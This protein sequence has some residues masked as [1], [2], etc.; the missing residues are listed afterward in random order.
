MSGF[1]WGGRGQR[2]GDYVLDEGIAVGG[3]GEVWLATRVL[4]AGQGGGV[5]QEQVAVKLLVDDVLEE[6][7]KAH[8]VKHRNVVKIIDF[9]R[10]ADGVL[11]WVAMEYVDGWTLAQLQERVPPEA[12][13]P[14]SAVLDLAIDLCEGLRAVHEAS[15]SRDRSM[16]LVHRDIKPSNVMVTHDGQVKLLDFG[17]AKDLGSSDPTAPS[18]RCFTPRYAAPE[19]HVG[20]PVGPATDLYSAA[21]VVAELLLGQPV[22]PEDPESHGLTIERLK[23]EDAA[24]RR[25]DGARFSSGGLQDLL[26]ACLERDPRRRP[27]SAAD[28][29]TRLHQLREPLPDRP[30]ADALIHLLRERR[31]PPDLSTP[32]QDDWRA[33]VRRVQSAPVPRPV[34]DAWMCGGTLDLADVPQVPP[35]RRSPSGVVWPL[36]ANVAFVRPVSAPNQTVQQDPLPPRPSPEPAAA[37]TLPSWL[38]DLMRA[39]GWAAVI[40]VLIAAGGWLGVSVL[41]PK[42]QEML[43]SQPAPGPVVSPTVSEVKPEVPVVVAPGP[44]PVVPPPP[45]QPICVDA[46]RDGYQAC[47]P[48]SPGDDCDDTNGKVYP[49]AT[50]QCDGV[51]NDCNPATLGPNETLTA[52][53]KLICSPT[54]PKPPRTQ[55]PQ[56]T[57]YVDEDGDGYGGG[58]T[59]P[60]SKAD[61]SEAGLS[62]RSDDCN[63][64]PGVGAR[65]YPGAGEDCTDGIDGDCSG[66]QDTCKGYTETLTFGADRRDLGTAVTLFGSCDAVKLVMQ[67]PGMSAETLPLAS[68]GV[69]WHAKLDL[70]NKQRKADG[71]LRYYYVCTSGGQE[72]KLYYR[73]G[74]YMR[75]KA[76]P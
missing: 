32:L 58:S 18:R 40:G 44:T 21:L 2:F 7:A 15:D 38:P 76:L 41:W 43:A 14:L 20:E 4:G 34:P 3:F 9:G 55:T 66:T 42:V 1:R 17:I 25:I 35:E 65:I 36:G 61:C 37:L 71:S 27:S 39:F 48:S 69:T 5:L 53:G 64:T 45:P 19:Q 67:F 63:D 75:E 51:D 72:R 22:F 30:C 33:L 57:C 68:S 16:R 50:E 70:S 54:T 49:G 11:R 46:D 8:S 13:L 62:K 26:R 73:D 10:A 47:Q 24:V 59:R 60:S 31:L 29:L 52:Q 23:L 12:S 74:K 56:T 28:V 6:V